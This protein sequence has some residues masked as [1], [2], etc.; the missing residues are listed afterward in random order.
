MPDLE[1][2]LACLIIGV[3]FA[4]DGPALLAGEPVSVQHEGACFLG[5]VAGE[6]RFGFG[7]TQDI[8][9]GFQIRKVVVREDALPFLGA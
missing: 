3:G 1:A 6:C 8:L 4:R 9:A 7:I 2:C 5:D